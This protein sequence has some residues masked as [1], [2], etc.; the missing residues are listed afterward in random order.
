M[1]YS[2]EVIKLG[3]SLFELLSGALGLDSNHLKEM[4][5][6]EL[7]MGST[8]HSDNDFLTVLFQDHI[9]GLQVLHNDQWVDVPP[10]RSRSLRLITNDKFKSVEHRVLANHEGP[11]VA[12]AC[13]FSTTFQPSTRLYGPIKELLSEDN[14]PIYRETTVHE[15]VSYIA[16]HGLSCP[17]RYFKL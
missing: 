10:V 5:C 3:V 9:G 13:F 17:L 7:T 2:K 4:E 6:P 12:V 14:P 11:R 16:T 8:K 15:F 1:L